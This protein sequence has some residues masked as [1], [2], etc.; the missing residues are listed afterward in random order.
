MELRALLWENEMNRT[1]LFGLIITSFT[2]TASILEYFGHTWFVNIFDI[3]DI[4]YFKKTYPLIE[5]VK[6]VVNMRSIIRILLGVGFYI[7][8]F[9]AL[10]TYLEKLAKKL[11]WYPVIFLAII[12]E[13]MMYFLWDYEF[14]KTYTKWWEY[15]GAWH[16][17]FVFVGICL[18]VAYVNYISD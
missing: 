17:I 14:T 10:L 16:T 4:L 7:G 3:F 9:F 5:D 2:F 13:V 18:F 8:L 1:I 15:L 6:L 12:T 11:N